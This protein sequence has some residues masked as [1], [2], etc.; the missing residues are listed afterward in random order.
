MPFQKEI[1][2]HIEVAQQMVFLQKEI[3]QIGQV[4]KEAI[5]K[6]GKIILAGNGGSAA[7]A[8]HIAAELVGRFVA[9]R[10]A[11]PALALTTDTSIL[12]SVGNDFGY[13]Y[14]FQSL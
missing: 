8:Q 13:E 7:D 5:D 12:T 2:E 1:N 14:I 10:N 9:E 11:L 6:G 3:A 4:C